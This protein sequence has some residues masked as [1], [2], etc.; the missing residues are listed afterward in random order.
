MTY[1]TPC[2]SPPCCPAP[3]LSSPL[4]LATCP[5]CEHDCCCCCSFPSTLHTLTLTL[6]WMQEQRGQWMK[7]CRDR[8]WAKSGERERRDEAHH[9]TNRCDMFQLCYLSWVSY[10]ILSY[11]IRNYNERSLNPILRLFHA[12]PF[13]LLELVTGY[14]ISCRPGRPVISTIGRVAGGLNRIE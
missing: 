6:G 11:L 14:K 5:P 9:T 7:K 2:K 10:R 8:Q 13:C 4:L 12:L 1:S 3:L